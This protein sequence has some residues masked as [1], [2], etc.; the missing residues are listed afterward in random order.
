M[1]IHNDKQQ[2]MDR[3]YQ[4]SS[5]SLQRTKVLVDG[6]GRTGGGGFH[7]TS[8]SFDNP[9]IYCPSETNSTMD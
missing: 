1:C 7:A 6:V 4:D 5:S 2:M 9:L 3:C 8:H